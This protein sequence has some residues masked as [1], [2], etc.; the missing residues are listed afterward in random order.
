M[1]KMKIRVHEA[2]EDTLTLSET[3]INTLLRN[4]SVPMSHKDIPYLKDNIG[5]LTFRRYF[6]ND[7]AGG[8]NVAEDISAREVARILGREQLLDECAN[9]IFNGDGFSN[10]RRNRADGLEIIVTSAP[11]GH[12]TRK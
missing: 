8:K 3:D 9:A 10:F 5:H 6:F 7:L 2:S 4:G 11:V 12:Y 1:S